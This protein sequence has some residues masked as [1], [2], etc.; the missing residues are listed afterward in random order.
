MPVLH[1]WWEPDDVARPDLPLRSAVLLHPSH[2]GHDDQ[3]LSGGMRMPC[4]ACARPEC[5]KPSERGGVSI[6]SI[7]GIDGH[8]SSEVLGSSLGRWARTVGRDLCT[9]CKSRCC[10]KEC[11][12]DGTDCKAF[13]LRHFINV[14]ESA[15]MPLFAY[16]GRKLPPVRRQSRDD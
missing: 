8:R 9:L 10:A 12:H 15:G 16:G 13:H 1:A 5:D 7:Q 2:A 3:N 14:G 4:G 6:R 11:E